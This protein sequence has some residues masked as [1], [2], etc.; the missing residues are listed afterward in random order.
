MNALRFSSWSTL[1]R[2]LATASLL[3]AATPAQSASLSA[4]DDT[5]QTITLPRPAQRVLTL[6]PHTTE[7]VFAAGAGDRIVGT[8]AYSDYPPA[9]RAIPRVGDN[10]AFDLE[11]IAAMQPDLAV[12]W[13]HGN[14]QGQL[15]VL[16]K[17]GIP[18]FYS[19]PRRLDQLPFTL[20]RLGV[21]VGTPDRARQ[22]A[23][24]YRARLAALRQTYAARPPVVVFYQV[25]E[26]PLMT[27]NGA[28]MVSDVVT[29]CGGR[30]LFAA[31]ALLVPTVSTEAVVAGN[32]EVIV[33]ASMGATRAARPLADLQ[34]WKR[35]NGM[36]AVQRDNLFTIDG[37]LINRQGPRILEAA[38]I[39][40]QQLEMARSRR[41]GSKAQPH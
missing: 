36:T 24:V 16:A 31:E 12:V 37:D 21:L 39:L 23:A 15:A 20:E 11:R 9:A 17:L 4:V 7:L 27:L 10:K 38:E 32:P 41:P 18:V 26:Q 22:A 8:V 2:T 25:W 5:G 28:H 13:R 19:D 35:W 34:H 33:T 6:S 30:N 40:C 3:C 29:A 1:L 14:A